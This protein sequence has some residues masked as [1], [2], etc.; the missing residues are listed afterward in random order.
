MKHLLIA[1]T[2]MSVPTL[3]VAPASASEP[4]IISGVVAGLDG[5][6]ISTGSVTASPL[7]SVAVP[8]LGR[9]SASAPILPDSTFQLPSLAT[10]AYRICTTAP[11][12]AW[13]DS[14][15][16]GQT[17]T[18]A[19]LAPGQVSAHVTIALTKGALVPVRVN[20]PSQ[21]LAVKEGLGAQLLIG[22]A[23]DSLVFRSASIA[24]QD[25]SGR[26]YQVLIP[27][28]RALN[29]SVTAASFQLAGQTGKS[30][31]QLG[32]LFPVS[33]PSGQVPATL[34]LNVIGIGGIAVPAV[35]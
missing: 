14:C 16:W 23:G 30:L 27:F 4:G 35:P 22:V 32:N 3:A 12:T 9:T 24:S 26:N 31:P 20:D 33:V 18:V 34:V 8:G 29:I 25:A 2:L 28:G 21:L 15:E 5:S 10:G 13:L 6:A 19:I 7:S 17:G 11:A 1:V